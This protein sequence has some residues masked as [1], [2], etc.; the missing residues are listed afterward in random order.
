MVSAPTPKR[1]FDLALDGPVEGKDGLEVQAG[2]R[3][4]RIEP[5]V[6]NRRLVAT[7]TVPCTRCNGGVPP[8]ARCAQEIKREADDPAPRPRGS[9]SRGIFGGEPR[10]ISSSLCARD[11]PR[12]QLRIR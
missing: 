6:A 12:E 7:S 1:F 10:R 11:S 8:S 5:C 9:C 2:E 4:Q 3:L